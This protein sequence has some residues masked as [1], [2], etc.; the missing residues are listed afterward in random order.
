MSHDGSWLELSICRTT[1]SGG[2]EFYLWENSS[3]AR[4][5]FG[6]TRSFI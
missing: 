3:E 6:R 2:N 4:R 1:S 5:F